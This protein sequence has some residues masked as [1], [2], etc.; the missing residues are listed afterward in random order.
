MQTASPI[1][2]L[3][4]WISRLAWLNL[5]WMLFSLLGLLVAGVFPA[6]TVVLQMIRRYL[7]G[8][9]RVSLSDFYREW[10]REL[11]RSNLSAWPLALVLFSLGWYLGEGLDA[12][13]QLWQLLSLALVP[14]IL[15]M[16]MGLLA[17]LLQNSVYTANV[18]GS[19]ANAAVLLQRLPGTLLAGVMAIL[20]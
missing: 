4:T 17:L 6:T 16:A 12:G 11:V 14:L 20:G 18:T 1:V 3:S 15:L 5:C 19:W 7:D 13:S 10:R 2:L 8:A 9:A